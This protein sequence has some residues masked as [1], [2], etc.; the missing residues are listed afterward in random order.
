MK[1]VSLIIGLIIGGILSANMVVMI[2]MMYTDTEFKGNDVVGYAAMVLLFSLV[3]VGIR[4]HRNKYLDGK[5]TFLQAF[6]I[7]ALICLVASTVY[8]VCWLFYYYL[9][10]PD[11]M[12]VYTDYVLKI[13]EPELIE[14]KKVEMADFKEMYKN[15]LFVVLMTYFEVLPIGLIVALISAF[16][17]KKK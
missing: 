12:D 11:F 9:V 17:A 8:V 15:P 5:I 2:N 16:I 3:Y 10:V 1:K 13:S 14:A 4:N 6:K 7:G